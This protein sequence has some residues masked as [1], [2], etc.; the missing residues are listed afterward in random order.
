MHRPANLGR[1]AAAEV[2][3]VAEVTLPRL[4]YIADVPVSD[5]FAGG[6]L[7]HRLLRFYPKDELLIVSPG[8][9]ADPLPGVRYR[10]FHAGWRRLSRSRLVGLHWRY[11][12]L[13]ARF[14]V[15]ALERTVR[16]FKPQAIATVAQDS[17][18]IAAARLARRHR[19][20]LHLIV[21]DDWPRTGNWPPS[22]QNYCGHLFATV[23]RAA[24]SRCCISPAMQAAYARRY[25]VAGSVIYPALD[26][27]VT[28]PSA[29]AIRPRGTV[30]LRCVY[31]GSVNS[32]GLAAVLLRAGRALSEL[33][34]SLT[35]YCAGPADLIDAPE[36]HQAG[37]NIAVALPAA[38]LRQVMKE[39]ADILLLPGSF[40]AWERAASA[41]A[42]PT[43]LTDYAGTGLPLL[44]AAPPDSAI[45]RWAL[46]HGAA[47]GLAQEDSD[48]AMR[49]AVRAAGSFEARL[50]SAAQVLAFARSHLAYPVVRHEFDRILRGGM[51]AAH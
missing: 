38:A 28:I 30:A 26:P 51:P 35:I 10:E 41:L 18:W 33:G 34:H 45:C 14:P 11:L 17:A 44:V 20:P 7:M 40:T 47:A 9:E 19:L 12:L 43:K 32:P 36:F 8:G 37:I 27:V 5:S 42:F 4:L 21:H 48:D 39:T 2:A 25:G 50:A 49:A 1:P 16:S 13:R 24:A 29:P 22:M 31:A 46:Q 23:Y 3:E 15:L 6:Q